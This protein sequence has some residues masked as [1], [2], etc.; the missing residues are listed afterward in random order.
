MKKPKS[1]RILIYATL[2]ATLILMTG[3]GSSEQKP[4]SV[5]ED[6]EKGRSEDKTEDKAEK[7]DK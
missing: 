6:N 1:I 5:A 2:I 4:V 7:K 3:C